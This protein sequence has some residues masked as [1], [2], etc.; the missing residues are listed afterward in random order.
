MKTITTVLLTLVGV[1][2]VAGVA[3]GGYTVFKPKPKDDYATV[4]SAKP[5]T[6]TWSE[7]HRECHDVTVQKR[8]PAQDSNDIAGTVIGAVVGGVIGHQFGGGRGK[9]A[10][11]AAGAVAGGY[12]GRKTQQHMQTNDTY[13]TTEQRCVTVNKTHSKQDGYKVTY[14]YKGQRHTVHMA[15][16]PGDRLPVDNGHVV[17][18]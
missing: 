7:P 16:D 9:D 2:V 1:A 18:H 17:T 3:Y 14:E 5:V 15:S 13:S 12:A 8:K 10:A 6:K 4:V 11:T